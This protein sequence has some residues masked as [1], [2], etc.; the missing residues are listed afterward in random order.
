M[1]REVPIRSPE[2][3]AKLQAVVDSYIYKTTCTYATV[4]GV[5]VVTRG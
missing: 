1:L 3:L 4:N 2:K 5:R